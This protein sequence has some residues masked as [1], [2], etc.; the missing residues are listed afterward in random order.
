MALTKIKTKNIKTGS[1]SSAKIVPGAVVVSK[2][3]IT[4]I[5]I[6]NSTYHLLD[7]TAVSTDGGYI[8]ITGSGFDETSTVSIDQTSALSVTYVNSTTLRAQVDSANATTYNVYVVNGDGSV[9]IKVNGLTY[10]SEPVWATGSTLTEQSADDSFSISFSASE[11]IT[12]S[13]T[14]TLPAG[15][16]LLSNGYFYGTITV[17]EDTTYTFTILATDTENQ[18]ASRSFDL[19]VT[20]GD[21]YFYSTVLL[22]Q[23]DN[24]T[25]NSNNNIF[26]DSSDNNLTITRSGE[27]TQTSFSPSNPSG[28]S[29]YFDSSGDYLTVPN[30]SAFDFGSSDWTVEAWLNLGTSSGEQLFWGKRAS[31]SNFAAVLLGVKASGT[32]TNRAFIIGSTSVGSWNVTATTGSIDIPLNTWVHLAYVRDGTNIRV[33]VNGV[34]DFTLSNI[35][36]ALI[37]NSDAQVIGAS[38]TAGQTGII[39]GYMSDVRCVKG[40]ALYTSNFTPS[41]N[42]LTEVSGTSLLALRS[43]RFLDESTNNFSI[44]AY[45]DTSIIPFTPFTP[46]AKYSPST[47]GASMYFDGN[48]DYLTI[49]TGTSATNFGTGDFTIEFWIFIENATTTSWNP[50]MSMG[51]GG[52]GQEIRIGQNING[53]GFG[54]IIPNN[55]NNSDRY[56]SYGLLPRKQWQ[57]IALVRNGSNVRVYKNGVDIGGVTDAGF[58]FTN[59]LDLKVGYG[60]YSNDSYFTGGYISDLRIVKGTAVYTTAFTPPTEPLQKIANTSLLLKGSNFGIYDATTKNTLLTIGNTKSNTSIKKYGTGSMY[61]DGTNSYVTTLTVEPSFFFDTNKWTIEAWVYFNSLTGTPGLMCYNDIFDISCTSTS[62]FVAYRNTPAS[63]KWSEINATVSFQ[64]E[65]W[66]HI[67][68]VLNNGTM[69]AYVDGISVGTP[70][71]SIGA[72]AW[73]GSGYKKFIVGGVD[74]Y[75][76]VGVP[77]NYLNGYIDDLRI[78]RGVARY[79]S[80]FT[81]PTSALKSK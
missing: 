49:P 77:D 13:N 18:E 14:T 40:T 23:A 41:T 74:K 5:A 46:S 30:N 26:V 38:S 24:A 1:I 48:G 76:F 60:Y 11:A 51:T 62:L 43:N 6:A 67:A 31:T 57:H 25:S 53:G 47:Y 71:T 27:T 54:I 20:I 55:S 70:A 28:W 61:F 39:N 58:N 9:G 56:F 17:V 65:T 42:Q 12:Y 37:S 2:P 66:Y 52:G 44:T 16:T 33:Y 81:P 35:S 68:V 75:S 15:T 32:G 22:L 34:L 45:G 8:V 29:A 7:D 59:T 3:K 63:A 79:T 4:N 80:N 50:I 64:T 73:G 69:T 72:P 10:S 36:G 78:T 19:T 21:E